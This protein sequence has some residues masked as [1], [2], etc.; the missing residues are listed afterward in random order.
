M[1]CITGK[2]NCWL[3]AF[4]CWLLAVGCSSDHADEQKTANTLHVMPYTVAYQ[5][6]GAL[7]RRAVSTGYTPYT[8][9]HDVSIGLFVLPDTDNPPTAKLI[10]YSSGDWHSQA[11]VE[12]DH[13][14]R[15][16]GF[17]PKSF[18]ASISESAGNTVMILTG[19][20]SVIADDVCFITGVKD[21]TEDLLQGRFDYRGKSDNNYV[22]LLM[23]HLFAAVSLNFSV[24]AEYS[25]LR[26]IKL[27]SLTLTSTVTSVTATVTLTPNATGADPV[28]SVSYV[29]AGTASS[30]ATFFENTSGIDITSA[31]IGN[32]F[33]CFAP[34]QGN[35]LTLV[36]TYDVYDRKGNK[37]RENCTAPNKLPNLNA[38]RGQ[39]VTLNLH[40][41]PTYLGVLSDPDL[42]H[43]TFTVN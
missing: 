34:E 9:D 26:T 19:I 1:K 40:V 8:P 38:A 43:P 5:D 4:G 25:A 24:D 14:Y 28:T 16:Y 27:K 36:S 21:N 2:F 3:L 33:C 13:D 18:D 15:I 23:D 22:R 31:E 20:P 42:D 37:I 11:T 12:G 10:R 7:T 6:N 35:T 39:R 30:S 32:S 29:S 17:M 41:A